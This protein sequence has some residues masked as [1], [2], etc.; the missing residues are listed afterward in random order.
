I[1]KLILPDASNKTKQSED[2]GLL[3]FDADGDG[4]LDLYIASGSYE[5][6]PNSPAYQDKFFLNDGKG[7]FIEDSTAIPKNL[8]S[9]SCVRAV[10]YD[11]DGDLDL[12][13][14]GRVEPWNYPKAVSSFIYR[15]D[16]KNGVVHF[17]DVTE[18][19]AP[20]LK[21]VGL[22]C[23]ALWTDIDNDGWPDLLLAGEWMPMKIL[24]NDKGVF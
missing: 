23:D 14:A 1:S 11:K 20:A 13:I 2:M 12:F 8:T 3:L 4:D 19:V 16:S 18:Q 24:K 9:K 6:A 7:N 21:N 5:N 22:V 17:T 15:N 10:D